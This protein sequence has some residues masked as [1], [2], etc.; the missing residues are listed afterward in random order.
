MTLTEILT[1]IPEL[2]TREQLALLEAVS[3]ALRAESAERLLGVIRT[4]T[5]LTDDDLDHIRFE[6]LMEKHS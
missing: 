1:K 4:D 5:E 6:Q 3:R 2:T